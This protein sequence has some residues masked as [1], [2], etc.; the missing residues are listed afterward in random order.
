MDKAR[1]KTDKM[2]KKTERKFS[3][4]YKDADAKAITKMRAYLFTIEDDENRMR[5]LYKTKAI[6]RKEYADW[7]QK[8]LLTGDKWRKVK[9]NIAFEYVNANQAAMALTN[10]LVDDV[11]VVNYNYMTDKLN[12]LVAAVMASPTVLKIPNISTTERLKTRPELRPKNVKVPKD[13]RWNENKINAEVLKGIQ[14]GESMD[15]IA[16]RLRNVTDMDRKAAIR[17][18]RTMVT[19]AENGARQ[20]TAEEMGKIGVPTVKQWVAVGDE[21]TRESH[22]DLDG[23]TVMYNDSF[24][25]GLMFAGDPSGDYAEVFNCRCSTDYMIREELLPQTNL[26][27]AE[28][29]EGY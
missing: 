29:F 19:S 14:K 15:K 25:N 23:E 24:S 21:R 10:D 26:K 22:L 11:F 2:L 27:E 3:K 17:N 18:A 6:T 4:I 7:R 20:A 16:K 8:T 13:L 12:G 1:K 28:R 9:Q 5:R